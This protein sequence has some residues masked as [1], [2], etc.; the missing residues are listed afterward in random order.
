M[1]NMLKEYKNV[2]T[3]YEVRGIKT[4]FLSMNVIF[5]M[6]VNSIRWSV[7]VAMAMESKG[8]SGKNDRTYL[9]VIR[10]HWYDILFS[11][12]C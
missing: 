6:L 5:T 4:Y 3:S 12:L 2:R 8:F 1:P 7:C 11:I 9:E 10:V